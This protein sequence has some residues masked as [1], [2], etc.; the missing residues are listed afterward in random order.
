MAQNNTHYF[1]GPYIFNQADS[2][3]IQWI[4]R[5][6]RYDTVILK[7]R[8]GIFKRDSLPIVNLHDL[9]FDV[10]D[11]ARFSNVEKVIAL[12]DVHGQYD[13]LIQLLKSH[14]V[15][16]QEHKW[17]FGAGHLMVIGDNF[18]RGDKVLDIL[19]FL[20]NLQKEA[21]RHGGK[22]HVLLG[23]HEM[24][25][26]QGDLRYLNRKYL[27]TSAAFKT[28][29][30][31]FFRKG[32]VLGD[33]L[34]HHKVLT[35]INNKLF[36]HA[37]VSLTVLDLGYTMEEL[38]DLFREKII[39][40]PEESI[41]KQDDLSLLYLDN[42]PLW[43]R[44][45]FDSTFAHS[46]LID[47]ILQRWDQ[48]A[49]VVG[50]TSLN[51]ISQVNNDKI[52][53]IDCSIKLGYGGQVLIL[54]NGEFFIGHMDG[55]RTPLNQDEVFKKTTLFNHIYRM[56]KQPKIRLVTD[57]KHLIKKRDDEVSQTALFQVLGNSDDSVLIL[58]CSVRARGNIRKKVC[59]FP[60]LKIDFSKSELDSIGFKKIDKLKFVLPCNSRS[61]SVD[62]LFKEYFLYTL[63]QIIDTNGLQAK[64]VE[65][66][67]VDQEKEAYEMLGIIIEDEKNYADRKNAHIVEDGRLNSQ[68]LDR[69]SFLKM[70]FFQYMI[71]N[72]DWT[73]GNKHNLEIVK[74]PNIAR[75]VALPYDFD[76]SGFVGQDYAV[77]APSLPIQS[78]HERYFHNYNITEAEFYSTVDYFLSIEEQIYAHCERATYMSS[79]TI[80]ANKAYLASFFELLRQPEKLKKDIIGKK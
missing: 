65:I 24:M 44:G 63:Y 72:T 32:S 8:A 21:E 47:T 3:R 36:V 28:P 39:R 19:W 61:S 41:L 18:D 55:E 51:A 31:R 6:M 52:V 64:L 34:A 75:V 45:Y 10:D 80:E 66:S 13:I 68:S 40:Q 22:V 7:E 30:H 70:A 25:V 2:L 26:L 73:V 53:G 67:L 78:V 17:V 79:K 43:Y 12:S 35:S 48:Q 9:N 76:Y 16:D 5:G 37:G 29:Y 57:V 71:C 49:V 62:Y 50:H 1:D 59:W 69:E 56:D 60:P 14:Q 74:L 77:P 54:E 27:Y 38:N 58:S 15:I 46:N 11:Q 42:G 33:W 23:N 4:E 20:F